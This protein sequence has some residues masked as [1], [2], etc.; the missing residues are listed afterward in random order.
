M[1]IAAK[2]A[3]ALVAGNACI[4]KPPSINSLI[5]LKFAEMVSPVGPPA[6]HGQISLR[7][8]AVP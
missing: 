5:G 7:D 3:P 8:R 4:V 2:L 1:M 6:G